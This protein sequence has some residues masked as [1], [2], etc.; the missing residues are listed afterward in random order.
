MTKKLKYSNS[1][2]IIM[3][4]HKSII[5]PKFAGSEFDGEYAIEP[6]AKMKPPLKVDMK[7]IIP[8]K[9]GECHLSGVLYTLSRCINFWLKIHY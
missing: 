6:L 4:L 2:L 3:I 1:Y 7:L 8:G 9:D 5:K